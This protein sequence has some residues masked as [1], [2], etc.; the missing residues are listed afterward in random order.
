MKEKKEIILIT[1]ASSDIGI[2]LIKN[3][4]SEENIIIAHYNKSEE[5]INELKKNVKGEIFGIQA[6]FL[7]ELSIQKFITKL[8]E[9][10]GTPDKIVH[11]PAEKFKNIRFRDCEWINFQNEIDIQLKSAVFILK[12]LLPLMAK[13][14]SGKVVFIL[15][16]VVL[17]VPPK[18]LSNYVTIKYAMLGLMKSLAA[19]YGDKNI[20]INAV[21]PSMIETNFLSEIHEK[22]IEMSAE[23]NPLKRNATTKDIVPIIKFLLSEESDYITGANI[24]ITGGSAF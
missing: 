1:G 17:N 10:V 24:P 18:A 13:I 7:D 3:I 12:E 9:E 20:N 6:N 11:I 4:S 15:S 22:V 2:E 23:M 21:S 16:S 8:K 5:K 14:K 19:E